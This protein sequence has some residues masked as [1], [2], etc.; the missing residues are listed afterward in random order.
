MS[1]P[2]LQSVLLCISCQ[3]LKG[4]TLHSVTC[5][6]CWVT[7]LFWDI[8]LIGIYISHSKITNRA[9]MLEGPEA[10][11]RQLMQIRQH[12]GGMNKRRKW[13]GCPNPEAGSDIHP[14]MPGSSC[15]ESCMTKKGIV[16]DGSKG[17]G[18]GKGVKGNLIKVVAYSR[19]FNSK[20]IRPKA[21][22]V[23][24]V[25]SLTFVVNICSG[26]SFHPRSSTAWHGI[27][28]YS[29]N[30]QKQHMKWIFI[31][32][33]S[34]RVNI[35]ALWVSGLRKQREQKPCKPALLTGT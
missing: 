25:C 14:G 22:D 21:A 29:F 27:D 18:W 9:R 23:N 12:F 13:R 26:I 34:N 6:S 10:D 17:R 28:E 8:K 4:M 24:T 16:S 19:I 2:T 11:T 20:H 35:T 7:S 1:L 15:F 32:Y 30:Y 5:S 33:L 3:E 31:I